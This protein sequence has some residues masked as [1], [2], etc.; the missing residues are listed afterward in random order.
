MSTLVH[1]ATILAQINADID[2]AWPETTDVWYNDP[3]DEEKEGDAPYGVI[4]LIEVTDSF[5]ADDGATA[6]QVAQVH[7]IDIVGRWHRP[8]SGDT[9]D[10]PLLF[11]IAK[12]DLLTV[13]LCGAPVYAGVAYSPLITGRKFDE[14]DSPQDNII[15]LRISFQCKVAVDHH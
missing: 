11:K 8:V 9:I 5:E 4:L 13:K 1:T 6:L 7:N 3:F 2:L 12:A 14:D 15:G 10:N